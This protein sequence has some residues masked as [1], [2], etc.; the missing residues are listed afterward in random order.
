MKFLVVDDS[1]TMRRIVVN[2]LKRIGFQEGRIC[3]NIFPSSPLHSSQ[4]RQVASP[5]NN[6]PQLAR[7]L[8]FQVS[9]ELFHRAHQRIVHAT[10]GSYGCVDFVGDS[11]HQ[12]TQ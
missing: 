2:S 8:F 5:L 1:A 7:V 9:L 12:T 3:G 6:Q 4:L 10:N 11:S